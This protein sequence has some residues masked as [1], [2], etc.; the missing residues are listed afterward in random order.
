MRAG[1]SQDF[2]RI[3]R[4]AEL[5]HRKARQLLACSYLDSTSLSTSLLDSPLS[6]QSS[7]SS[8]SPRGKPPGSLASWRS[9]NSESVS[10]S[11]LSDSQV[12][13][14][15]FAAQEVF[16]SS[17]SLM[18]RVRKFESP[19]RAGATPTRGKRML[20]ASPEQVFASPMMHLQRE[21]IRRNVALA[22]SALDS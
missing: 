16:S 18:D 19:G 20:P 22:S 4:C 17:Q 14:L 12:E 15:D 5:I 1:D 9:S 11:V 2:R 8:P 10:V 21:S 7:L 13:H 6:P 3:D